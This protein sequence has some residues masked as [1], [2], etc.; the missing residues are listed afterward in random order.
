MADEFARKAAVRDAARAKLLRRASALLTELDGVVAT[1]DLTA[2]SVAIA[3]M[4]RELEDA[5]REDDAAALECFDDTPL[6]T[7][8]L[9]PRREA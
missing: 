3:G 6:P 2:W 5:A 7:V 9:V 8:R 1:W 4:K